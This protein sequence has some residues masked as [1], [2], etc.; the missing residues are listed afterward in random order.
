HESRARRP[1]RESLRDEI[2]EANRTECNQ[3]AR[4][5]STRKRWANERRECGEDESHRQKPYAT[6]HQRLEKRRC[7]VLGGQILEPAD[8][9]DRILHRV[10][11]NE[12]KAARADRKHQKQRAAKRAQRSASIKGSDVPKRAGAIH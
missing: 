5:T 7:V 2:D 8:A 12:Q 9:K 6:V 3:T 10:P 4:A 1:D 11:W